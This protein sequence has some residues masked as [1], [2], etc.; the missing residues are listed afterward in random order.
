ME[1]ALEVAG[2]PTGTAAHWSIPSEP[3]SVGQ[4][5]RFLRNWLGDVANSRFGEDLE[6]VVSELVTNA[7]R[8]SRLLSLH[9]SR[10]GERVRVEVD[11]ENGDEPR[12]DSAVPP[13]A[14]SGRGLNIVA[15]LAT[16]WGWSPLSDGGKRVWCELSPPPVS[17]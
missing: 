3:A 6:L 11:D 10:R 4:A 8:H 13:E 5:R 7:I 17:P 16:T 2:F 9:L 14:P 12:L 15:R 1:A